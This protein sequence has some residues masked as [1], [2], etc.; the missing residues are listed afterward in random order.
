MGCVLKLSYLTCMSIQYESLD[1]QGRLSNSVQTVLTCTKLVTPQAM[2]QVFY[3][4]FNQNT[5]Q[6]IEIFF[7]D[8]IMNYFNKI[9]IQ[10]DSTI[11]CVFHLKFQV[12][13]FLYAGKIN[14]GL[15]SLADI[16]QVS[17]NISVSFYSYKNQTMPI[18]RL[19]SSWTFRICSSTSVT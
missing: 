1:S 10:T 4:S 11:I 8:M 12:L 5:L 13:E 2:N 18:I 14:P 15:C 7:K 3:D 17:Q 6:L 16:K 19:L 9:G